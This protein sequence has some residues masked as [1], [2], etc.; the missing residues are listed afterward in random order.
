MRQA[1][2]GKP[3]EV[4][5]LE[6]DPRVTTTEPA[7]DGNGQPDDAME[8]V[9]SSDPNEADNIILFPDPSVIIPFPIALAAAGGSAVDGEG[10]RMSAES[11]PGSRGPQDGNASTD[12]AGTGGAADQKIVPLP[13]AAPPKDAVPAGR[14]EGRDDDDGIDVAK[15]GF[16][17]TRSEDAAEKIQSVNFQ[18]EAPGSARS[19][20][21]NGAV[22][23]VA[24]QPPN[25]EDVN[26]S[27]KESTGPT[28]LPGEDASPED[29]ARPAGYEPAA[30]EESSGHR[31]GGKA[32]SSTVLA[33]ST[34]LRPGTA[35]PAGTT[36]ARQERSMNFLMDAR[37][38]EAHPPGVNS[39]QGEAELEGFLNAS[40]SLATD[41]GAAPEMFPAH[42]EAMDW[43]LGHPVGRIDRIASEIST[44]PAS[45]GGSV[46]R[47]SNLI[48]REAMLVRQYKSDALAVVLRP[49][50]ETELFVHFSQRNGQIEATVRCERGDLQQLGALWSQLQESLGQQ[51]I[52]LAPLQESPSHQS[53]FNSATGSQTGGGNNHGD[54]SP[55][56]S[57]DK[58]SLDEWPAPATSAAESRHVRG[59]GGSG[60]RR[61]TTSRPGW[62][63]WA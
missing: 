35:E 32:P 3:G 39:V 47:L 7:A 25:P 4:A 63:T 20:E 55:R 13:A 1:L 59:G 30:P 24:F 15:L 56:H 14:Q 29:S 2:T 53:P 18:A 33:G 48:V 34:D 5:S 28:Q 10:F 43:Q 19:K 38:D 57:P 36:A 31:N 46:E 50:A 37:H 58:Q 51:K 44:Q 42:L 26:L 52:R 41:Q 6:V 8:T 21:E 54:P 12:T 23:K 60:H 17:P 9:D 61:V 45:P 11:Q 40:S 62:E 27:A 22:L 49:D 16:K